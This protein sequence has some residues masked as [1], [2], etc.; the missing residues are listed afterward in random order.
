MILIVG[1]AK[2]Y[3]PDVT[4]AAIGFI[5]ADR[6]TLRSPEKHIS[7]RAKTKLRCLLIV[8]AVDG[9]QA[10]TYLIHSVYVAYM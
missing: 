7:T 9:A 2:I 3:A 4:T 10:I 8:C 5:L 6:E 1:I